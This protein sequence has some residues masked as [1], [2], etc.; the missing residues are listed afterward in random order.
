[1]HIL[2][3][4]T[5]MTS[6][7]LTVSQ[8]MGNAVEE[9]EVEGEKLSI[10]KVYVRACVAAQLENIQMTNGFE[11]VAEQ[12][13]AYNLRRKGSNQ[14]AWSAYDGTHQAYPTGFCCPSEFSTSS[15]EEAACNPNELYRQPGWFYF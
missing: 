15:C 8:V 6:T 14:K 7:A 12:H 2:I 4:A 11:D 9:M 10:N 1:M 5:I 3:L 13:A